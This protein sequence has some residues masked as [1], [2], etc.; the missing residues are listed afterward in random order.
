MRS[1][2]RDIISSLVLT[3]LFEGQGF[4]DLMTVLTV[5]VLSRCLV[6]MMM[7][8]VTKTMSHLWWQSRAKQI[9]ITTTVMLPVLSDTDLTG[10]SWWCQDQIKVLP[11]RITTNGL[12][13]FLSRS[14]EKEEEE[15]VFSAAYHSLCLFLLL[16]LLKTCAI[17]S[18]RNPS[19]EHLKVLPS[20][21]SLL[22][23][24]SQHL[25]ERTLWRKQDLFCWIRTV[26]TRQVLS[27][28]S[29]TFTPTVLLRHRLRMGWT[30]DDL[31]L[32]QGR[33]ENERKAYT[34]NFTDFYFHL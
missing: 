8:T 1:V 10:G 3:G 9:G 21:L 5:D 15:P 23:C 31:L 20:F 30:R 16:F 34:S 2:V 12:R 26:Q 24:L 27:I 18:I 25:K 28:F 22:F 7:T 33:M 32:E 19:F 11:P 29:F 14:K 6:S 4:D 17:Q 13:A